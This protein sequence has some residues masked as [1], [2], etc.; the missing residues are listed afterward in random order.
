MKNFERKL[1][2]KF[3]TRFKVEE[4]MS[5]HTTFKIGGKAKYFVVVNKTSELIFVLKLCAKFNINYFIIGAGSNLLV[6]D[7]GFNGVVIS[8]QNFNKI[9]FIKNNKVEAFAG[10]RIVNVV[11]LCAKNC[12]GGL[13]WAINIP[14][15]IGGAVVMNAGAFNN[16]ISDYIDSVL[17]LDKYKLKVFKKENLFFDYRK[18]I[19]TNQKKYVIIKVTLNLLPKNYEEIVE[20]QNKYIELRLKSQQVKFASAGSIFKRTPNFSA[21]ELIDKARL[22][23]LCIGGAMVSKVHS[24]YIVNTGNATANDVLTLINIIKEKVFL[25]FGETLETEI[26]YLGENNETTN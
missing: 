22:K 6:S 17:V 7:N 11:N 1:A 15:T 12:F 19:F 9:N 2:L 21:A 26:V 20:Q 5:K 8:M 10:A 16:Q 25:K 13:E 18:S 23:G 24:G 4:D 3:K 14:G